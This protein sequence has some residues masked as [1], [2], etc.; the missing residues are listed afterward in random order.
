MFT[1]AL[2]KE[3]GAHGITVNAIAPGGVVTPGVS[4]IVGEELSEEQKQQM[5]AQ[6]KQFIQALPLKRM[7]QPEEIARIALFLASDCS[8]YM[9]GSIVVADGGLL[10]I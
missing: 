6:T 5:Q 9:T 8:S 7:G 4:K 1:K 3:V 10:L 2:A